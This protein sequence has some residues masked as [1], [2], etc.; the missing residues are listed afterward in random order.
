VTEVVSVFVRFR[1][2]KPASALRSSVTRGGG[3]PSWPLYKARLVHHPAAQAV[4]SL[5]SMTHFQSEI[6]RRW[7]KPNRALHVETNHT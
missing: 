2:P 5:R 1:A 3:Y 7:K 4:L 6:E